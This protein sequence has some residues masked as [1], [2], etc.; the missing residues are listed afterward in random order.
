[1]SDIVGE[2]A[3]VSTA[4]EQPTLGLLHR[5]DAAVIL[6]LFRSTFSN[7]RLSVPTVNLHQHVET[8][9]GE[10]KAAGVTPLPQ[11]DGR[12][13]CQRWMNGQWLVRS[14]EDDGT[15]TYSLT[16]HAREALDVVQRMMRDRA[17]L[18]EHRIATIVATARRFNAEAN[19]DRA[20][21]IA[22]LDAEIA[23]RT[24]E[25]N[26]LAE[27]GPMATV[28]EESMLLRYIELQ[29]LVSGLP[30]DFARVEE[31]FTTLRKT[32]LESFRAEGVGAGRVVDEYL[33]RAENLMSSTAE[34]RAFEGAFD[35]L[36]DE[37]L[38]LQLREDLNALLEHPLGADI[39]TDSDRREL[40]GIVRLIHT[41]IESVLT[42]RSKVTAALREY[43]A[44]HNPGRD[45]ELE[46]VL[47][48][49]DDELTRWMSGAGRRAAV[50]VRL[51]PERVEVTH[52]RERFYDPSIESDPDPLFSPEEEPPTSFSLQELKAHGGPTLGALRQHMND[53]F[54]AGK[55]TTL[56]QM[57]VQLDDDLRRPVEI[58]GALQLATNHDG[59]EPTEGTEQY[60]TVRPDG[61]K[62]TF[63]VPRMAARPAPAT[64]EHA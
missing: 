57:F 12:T 5:R 27:G 28:T 50:D 14:A 55:F 2:F 33:E 36:R 21:R 9:L 15:E 23:H 7:E 13:L 17:A 43:I 56:G 59:I 16:S 26:R 31:S 10:L 41:G 60:Q 39:L 64:G 3:R 4:F 46:H 29:G 45:R 38:L 18:S 11:G 30:S 51:I 40:R 44:T 1:M 22:I 61:R 24:A 62:R 6:A 34:G 53:L 49:L 52:L 54:D 63:T 58:L 8:C 47:R 37:A 19:P 35:L 32:L 20:S 42:R 48:K 25:R